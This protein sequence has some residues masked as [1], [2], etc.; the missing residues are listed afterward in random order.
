MLPQMLCTSDLKVTVDTHVT[1]QWAPDCRPHS[2]RRW[3]RP[4][5]TVNR[6]HLTLSII[7][8]NLHLT[9]SK[10]KKNTKSIYRHNINV[11]ELKNRNIYLHL[12]EQ[13]A[14]HLLAKFI[15]RSQENVV[16][17]ATAHAVPF[18]DSMI[19]DISLCPIA[20]RA[21]KCVRLIV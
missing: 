17:R 2:R 6:I 16:N 5:V 14:T 20:K 4:L 15:I 8:Q 19:N 7:E 12:E 3:R 13:W 9:I 10:K 11:F 1:W 18:I 21:I